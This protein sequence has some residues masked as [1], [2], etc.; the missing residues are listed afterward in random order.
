MATLLPLAAKYGACSFSCL[1]PTA[2]YRKQPKRQAIVNNIFQEAKK[3]GFT[4]DDFIVDCLVMAVASE[5]HAPG[6]IEDTLLV[7][8]NL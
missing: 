7:R 1:W 5:P 3:S 4:K 6:N 2:N 8:T